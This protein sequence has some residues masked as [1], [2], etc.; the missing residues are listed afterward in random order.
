[1]PNGP[2]VPQTSVPGLLRPPTTRRGKQALRLFGVAVLLC[3]FLIG[4]TGVRF[5]LPDSVN[6]ADGSPPWWLMV[7][8]LS[9]AVAAAISA[10]SGGVLAV[11]SFR[12]G[13]RSGLLAFPFACALIAVFFLVGELAFGHE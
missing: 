9:A 7:P 5:A 10:L 3:V 6:A 8:M 4:L 11:V 1:M 13:E 12:R 2:A